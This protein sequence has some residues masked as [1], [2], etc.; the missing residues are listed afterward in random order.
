MEL[1]KIKLENITEDKT[2]FYFT[3]NYY[4]SELYKSIDELGLLSPILVYKNS[5]KYNILDGRQRYKI[6]QRLEISEIECIILENTEEGFHKK[7]MSTQFITKKADH[8]KLAEYI[9]KN[10]LHYDDVTPGIL[11]EKKNFKNYRDVFDWKWSKYHTEKELENIVRN[12]DKKK[13]LF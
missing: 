8:F 6:Y 4:F 7:L 11:N 1:R 2:D 12:R 10:N 3:D 5:D 13:K 9:V